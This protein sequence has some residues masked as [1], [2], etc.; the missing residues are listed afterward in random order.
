M[1]VINSAARVGVAASAIAFAGVLIGTPTAAAGPAGVENELRYLDQLAS[2]ADVS[3][4]SEGDAV[5]AG[6][7]T[8]SIQAMGGPA[9]VT[10]YSG[11]INNQTI[12]RVA[13]Q[14][15][16]FGVA[17]QPAGG[18]AMNPEVGI[19][20]DQIN[21]NNDRWLDTDADDDGFSD[22]E[23]DFDFDDSAY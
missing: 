16:C 9:A 14:H 13:N 17:P 1:K 19:M 12:L 20:Q 2:V 10:G 5:T 7:L 21:N 22:S 23:D 3:S 15:L 4:L 18:P 8:C 6:Y 11:V